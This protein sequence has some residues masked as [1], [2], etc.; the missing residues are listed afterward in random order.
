M[1]G[2]NIPGGFTQDPAGI[3]PAEGIKK[4]LTPQEGWSHPSEK[5]NMLTPPITKMADGPAACRAE[6]HPRSPSRLVP[7]LNHQHRLLIC[8]CGFLLLLPTSA[9]C[10][11]EEE[12][13]PPSG[14]GIRL[15]DLGSRS[16]LG[17][18]ALFAGASAITWDEADEH[19]SA[20]R[21][22][23]DGS[24]L[25]GFMDAGNV[26]GSGWIVGG[27]TVGLT[28]AGYLGG[29]EGL[30]DTGID[31]G[32]SF[33]YSALVSTGIKVLVNRKRPS[34][35]PHSFPSGHTTSAFSTVPVVWH[36]AGWI[37]GL[38]TG[39][40]ATLTGFGRMEENRH[41]TSDVIA[42]AAL[43]LVVGRMV[44]ADR[45]DQTAWLNHLAVTDRSVALVWGF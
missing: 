32:R 28:A 40:L 36:H 14:W 44:V 23:L 22:S 35:G 17:I 26:F 5:Q 8:L 43:G 42:G 1:A 21:R 39:A 2:I 19:H 34:G 10:Q 7:M 38:G 29:G 16:N 41:Y 11:S 45:K 13:G 4:C 37:A 18:L 15:S 30:R 3:H 6:T 20:L 27:A 12:P 9:R 24:A 25:D 31:M 33:V